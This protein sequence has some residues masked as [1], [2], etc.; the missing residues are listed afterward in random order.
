MSPESI[1]RELVERVWNQGELDLIPGYFAETIDHG[2]RTDDVAGLRSWHEQDALIWTD[3]RFDIVSLVSDDSS[4]QVA[5]RWHATARQIGQWGPVPPTGKT[6]SWD[7]VH[8]FTVRDGKVVAMWAMADVFGKAMQLG[9]VVQP[10]AQE[11]S[12]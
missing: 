5:V 11:P 9:A 12:T 1:I 7:G 10:P 3:Q 8:F 4:G 6:I 2:G